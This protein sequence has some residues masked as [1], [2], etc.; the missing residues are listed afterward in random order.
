MSE[1]FILW[2]SRL[3]HH[4]SKIVRHLDASSA[5]PLSF[6]Y[7]SNFHC[8]S[9]Q[10]NKYH[11]LP[12]HDS[13]ITSSF[14]LELLFSNVWT[15]PIISDD[16]FKYY[17]IFVDHFTKYIW[18]YPLKCKCDVLDTFSQFKALVE[19]RFNKKIISLYTDN[20]GNL[21]LLHHF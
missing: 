10:I 5:T 6:T 18:F 7:V 1:S 20:W 11:K 8:N 4:S 2:H 16:G 13:T 9:C 15:S 19:N 17:V 21:L 12:F 14:P 3:G